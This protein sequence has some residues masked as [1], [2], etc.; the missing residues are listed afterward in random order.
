MRFLVIRLVQSK[1]VGVTYLTILIL[2][3]KV[4]VVEIESIRQAAIKNESLKRNLGVKLELTK[5]EG[6]QTSTWPEPDHFDSNL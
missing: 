5:R 6:D 3:D 1:N 4:I 2:V